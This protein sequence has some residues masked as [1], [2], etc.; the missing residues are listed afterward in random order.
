MPNVFILLVCKQDMSPPCDLGVQ[1]EQACDYW[2]MMLEA[3]HLTVFIDE[4]TE[5]PQQGQDDAGLSSL[6][7]GIDLFYRCTSTVVMRATEIPKY[8]MGKNFVPCS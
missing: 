6:M 7:V 1:S 4:P 2:Q 8:P 5:G 3:C